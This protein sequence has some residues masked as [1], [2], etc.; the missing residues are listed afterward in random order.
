MIFLKNPRF[1]AECEDNYQ[2]CE[3][4]VKARL[5]TYDFYIENCCA[6]CREANE[7]GY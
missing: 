7:H 5:C 1:F 3:V 4:A 2:N 6:S